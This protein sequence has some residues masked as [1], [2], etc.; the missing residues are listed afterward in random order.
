MPVAAGTPT[1]T[2][3]NDTEIFIPPDTGDGDSLP[4]NMIFILDTSGSM[5]NPPTGG[6]LVKIQQLLNAFEALLFAEDAT[7]PN[8]RDHSVLN[9]PLENKTVSIMRFQN[10]GSEGGFFIVNPTLIDTVA[11]A[12]DVWCKVKGNDPAVTGTADECDSY[13]NGLITDI[14][15]GSYT[16]LSESL[17]EVT[18][19]LRQQSPVYGN[20]AGAASVMFDG[21]PGNYTGSPLFTN[22]AVN[23]CESNTHVV[24][25]TDGEPTYDDGANTLIQSSDYA[26]T[27]CNGNCLDELAYYLA[28][29]DNLVPNAMRNVKVH[30]IAFDLNVAAQVALL[31]ATANSGQGSY[32]SAS[33][34]TDIETAITAIANTADPVSTSF[35]APALSVS[36]TNSFAHD[37]E[38]YYALFEPT[39]TTKWKGNL[40]AYQLD[41]GVIKDFSPTPINAVDDEGLFVAAAKDKWNTAT[42]PNGDIITAGG[43]GTVLPVP[44]SRIIKT[45]TSGALEAFDTTNVSPE[46]LGLDA[47]DTARRNAIVTWA[48]GGSTSM[49]AN[50]IGDPLHSQPAVV[51]YGGTTGKYV[52][53]GTNEGFLHAIDA[54]N[55]VEAFAFIPKELL[56]NLSTLET[57]ASDPDVENHPYGIDGNIVAWVNDANGDGQITTGGSGDHVYLYFGLRRGGS[58]YYALNVTDPA[59]PSILW[60]I[61]GGTGTSVTGLTFLEGLGETWSTPIKTKIKTGTPASPTDTDVLVFGGGYD[62]HQDYG[63]L[64]TRTDTVGNRVFIVNASTGALIWQAVNASPRSGTTD[65]LLT[66]LNY[67]IPS[68]IA[69]IDLDMDDVADR[70][71]FGDMG[72]QV[73]R[74]DLNA[75]TDVGGTQSYE[76]RGI[77]MADLSD[78]GDANHRR[79]YYAPDIALVKTGIKQYIS[80][81]IGSGYRASPKSTTFADRFYALRDD[82]PF[83]PLPV[84]PAGGYLT[85]PLIKETAGT[86]SIGTRP[87]ISLVDATDDI[88]ASGSAFQTIVDSSHQG[89]FIRLVTSGEKVLAP[90][91]TAGNVLLFTTYLNT[92]GGRMCS[93]ATGNGRLY[94]VN[95]FNGTGVRL[96]NTDP[97]NPTAYRSTDLI[98][99]GIPP[100]PLVFVEDK[101]ADNPILHT[102]VGT[103]SFSGPICDGKNDDP[104]CITVSKTFWQQI[105]Q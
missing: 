46:E 21:T 82:N 8:A 33:N 47:T 42:P 62:D 2:P 78:S 20:V 53:F 45:N 56:S 40:K 77:R 48:R 13:P 63:I 68:D 27:T 59:A 101:G 102:L 31:E 30:T 52:Y 104:L 67:S 96:D 91:T 51:N 64:P 16:P 23:T 44:N 95:L 17:F 10:G 94:I 32:Q 80:V 9:T 7:D 65:L 75:V 29:G 5:E 25:L 6:G 89:W 60:Q 1:P 71:Y 88:D 100:G 24:I 72:G 74:I 93:A 76:T 38:M 58:H 81:N 19:F 28:H 66:E 50:P 43:A 84:R 35:V 99:A 36:Q 61:N 12:Q 86:T 22:V 85:P 54:D 87:E 70:L 105:T 18:R 4:A 83:T 92:G 41:G 79:F 34:A 73:F 11:V 49:R 14:D 69:V 57:N 98:T 37:K 97:D 3:T 15:D 39:G 103:Q 90:A 55:G 26:N